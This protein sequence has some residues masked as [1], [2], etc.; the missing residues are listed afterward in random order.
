MTE[1]T[2]AAPG[3]LFAP[4]PGNPGPHPRPRKPS[5]VLPRGATDAHCHVF[6]PADVYPYATDRSF[7]PVDAPSD[8]VSARQ[9]FLGFQ[10]SV[11]V[12]S[13]GYGH[14]HRALL[15]ALAADPGNRRGVAILRPDTTAAQ[16]QE[17]HAAGI[18]GARL[19]FVDHLGPDPAPED[20]R[21][22]VRTLADAGWHAEIHVQD[23]G[24]LR[25]AALIAAIPAPVVIDHMAR[26]D[27]RE[28]LDSPS[29]RALLSLLEGGNTWVK[30]SGVDRLSRTGPPYTDAVALAALLAERFPERVLW[31]T[32][33]PHVNIV[34]AAPDDGLLVDL[35][36][37][38]APTA[39]AREQLLVT[40]P[41]QLFGFGAPR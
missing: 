15:D 13:S 17:L 20:A 1:T 34:G 37:L 25:H 23:N 14:D 29:V 26:V 19:H 2:G 27:L 41:A 31:G 28:G 7:T 21:R 8:E 5:L 10:R 16:I 12:Q 3:Q 38:I 30:L 4:S 39:A 6:G 35:I 40:N 32:D 33:Y 24:I 18:R 11:I 22:V 36:E 9:R